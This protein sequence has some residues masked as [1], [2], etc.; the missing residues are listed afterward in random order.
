MRELC[1]S[2]YYI[3][4]QINILRYDLT[5]YID[6]AVNMTNYM[7]SLKALFSKF[8]LRNKIN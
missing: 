1:N 3:I 7:I 8:T 4:T 2:N 6:T 5:T